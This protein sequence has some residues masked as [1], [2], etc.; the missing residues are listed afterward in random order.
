MV[1]MTKIML[2]FTLD[3]WNGP[4][5]MMNDN[6]N[7]LSAA[8]TLFI[9]VDFLIRQFEIYKRNYLFCVAERRN[10]ANGSLEPD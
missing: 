5:L 3:I 6:F 9:I 1:C 7:Y 8:V 4:V 10:G 2:K